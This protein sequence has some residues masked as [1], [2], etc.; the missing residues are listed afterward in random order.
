MVLT[1]DQ[2]TALKNIKSGADGLTRLL[3]SYSGSRLNAS[4]PREACPV[5]LEPLPGPEPSILMSGLSGMSI[6]R[7]VRSRLLD[8]YLRG[9]SKLR[10]QY[11]ASLSLSCARLQHSQADGIPAKSSRIA[12]RDTYVSMY[13]RQLQELA[14][15]YTT[16]V[17]A[18]AGR[19]SGDPPSIRASRCS[20]KTFNQDFMPVL[21][22]MFAV[23]PRPSHADKAFLAKKSGMA[24]RQIH[25]WFQNRRSRSKKADRESTPHSN[26]IIFAFDDLI[27]RMGHHIIPEK[28]RLE[29][30]DSDASEYEWQYE[31]TDDEHQCNQS[32]EQQI[33]TS[34]EAFPF[35]RPLYAFPAAYPY[36]GGRATPSILPVPCWHRRPSARDESPCCVDVDDLCGVFLQLHIQEVV[37]K[38]LVKKKP[39]DAFHVPEKCPMTMLCKPDGKARHRQ[40]S[41]TP[42]TNSSPRLRP[43]GCSS[44]NSPVS[45]W[46]PP[47]AKRNTVGPVGTDDSGASDTSHR[48]GSPCH[49]AHPI[50]STPEID[51]HVLNTASSSRKRRVLGWRKYSRNSTCGSSGS[52]YSAGPGNHVSSEHDGAFKTPSS[53]HQFSLRQKLARVEDH[54]LDAAIQGPAAMDRFSEAWRDLQQEIDANSQSDDADSESIALAFAVASRIELLANHFLEMEVEHDK[55]TSAFMNDLQGILGDPKLDSSQQSVRDFHQED[56]PSTATSQDNQTS[57]LYR[58]P[59]YKWLLQHLYDPYPSK[60]L[61]RS[62]ADSTGSS[63]ASIDTWFQTARRRMGWTKL[64]RQYFNNSRREMVDC[65]RRILLEDDDTRAED[66]LLTHEFLEMKAKAQTLFSCLFKKSKLAAELD[67][68]VKDMSEGDWERASIKKDEELAAKKR[69]R[70]LEKE[71]QRLDRAKQR[72]ETKLKREYDN[73]PSPAVFCGQSRAASRVPSLT[74]SLSSQG[75]EEDGLEEWWQH[76]DISAPHSTLSRKRKASSSG[77]EVAE[78]GVGR[79]PLMKRQRY[80]SFQRR[81]FRNHT[82]VAGL[83]EIAMNSTPRS[84]TSQ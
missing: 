38:R 24:Y 75:S 14:T 47:S 46:S 18:S 21:E 35:Q 25:V 29:P 52:S 8:A 81:L 73:C 66:S 43:T 34:Q 69:R 83:L 51:E 37:K 13:R 10:D 1:P 45:L 7:A 11:E 72:T 41:T 50:D 65:A 4:H 31:P 16:N 12:L 44:P 59:C 64:Q 79:E 67:V 76:A 40:G 54:F 60:D 3:E 39:Q 82:S 30:L 26:N 56:T 68:A 58:Q 80:A 70:A 74:R 23:N 62:I 49:S 71:L 32:A 27:Q 78:A 19:D 2:L 53:M 17:A 57:F 55:L 5:P 42:E 63:V 28:E 77:T 9:A 84:V 33:V 36:P 6:S 48:T 15:H 20:G 22:Y 61:K